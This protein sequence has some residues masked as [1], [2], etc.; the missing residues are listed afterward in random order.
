MLKPGC[1]G[2]AADTGG[3]CG[4]MGSSCGPRCRHP[5]VHQGRGPRVLMLQA[6]GAHV[7]EDCR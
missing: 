7:Y 4:V 5:R 2:V 6:W 1:R 3:T